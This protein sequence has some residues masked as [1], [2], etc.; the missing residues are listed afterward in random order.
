MSSH[1]S[2][3]RGLPNEILLMIFEFVAAD[4]EA[5]VRQDEPVSYDRSLSQRTLQSLVATCHRFKDLAWPLLYRCISL[6][7]PAQPRRLFQTLNQNSYLADKVQAILFFEQ[8]EYPAV[9]HM[10]IRPEEP[11]KNWLVNALSFVNW[12]IERQDGPRLSTLSDHR[13]AHEAA[14]AVRELLVLLMSLPN[15]RLLR[16][17]GLET[18]TVFHMILRTAMFK[19][20]NEPPGPFTRDFLHAT[21]ELHVSGFQANEWCHLVSTHALAAVPSLRALR[22]SYPFRR[23]RPAHFPHP[24]LPATSGD[25]IPSTIRDLRLSGPFHR[26]TDIEKILRRTQALEIFHWD[27]PMNSYHRLIAC[28]PGFKRLV[29]KHRETLTELRVSA[30]YGPGGIMQ[31]NTNTD[32]DTWSC[33]FAAYSRLRILQVPEAVFYLH[34]PLPADLRLRDLLPPNVEVFIL[35]TR[36]ARTHVSWLMERLAMDE[37]ASLSSCLK[38]VV[39]KED[40]ASFFDIGARSDLGRAAELFADCGV[41]FVH[42]GV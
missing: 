11:K 36:D 24:R 22:I 35:H 7:S 42:E 29:H 8:K 34:A 1:N 18:D 28:L 20:A 15:L 4:Q 39:V 21:E 13:N 31:P 10:P 33:S 14:N 23:L 12:L 3:P 2:N 5:Y 41:A 19:I 26:T 25:G 16:Y 17:A 6:P 32:P 30:K 37:A 9:S 38:R 27:I 40:M